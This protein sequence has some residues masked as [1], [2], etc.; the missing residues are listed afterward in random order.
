MFDISKD[1][2]KL[3]GERVKSSGMF[4]NFFPFEVHTRRLSLERLTI[5]NDGS[6]FAL[7]FD[8]ASLIQLVMEICSDV[9]LKNHC[10]TIESAF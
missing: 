2:C 8:I 7:E 10:L 5:T 3:I 6:A 9:G 1:F 4:F